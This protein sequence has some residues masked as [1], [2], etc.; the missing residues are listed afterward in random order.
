MR[1]HQASCGY[2]GGTGKIE[3]DTIIAY[4]GGGKD[5]A[6]IDCPRCSWIKL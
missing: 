4:H 3:S 6:M 1:T 2:C 5:Y